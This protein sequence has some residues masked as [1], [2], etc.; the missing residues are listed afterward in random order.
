MKKELYT[1]DNLIFL[2][3]QPRAGS[4]LTQRILGKHHKIHTTSE[5]WLMLRPLYAFR[6]EENNAEYNSTLAR[7]GLESFLS[8]LPHAQ[9]RKNAEQI[10]FQSVAQMYGELYQQAIEASGKDFFLDKTPR[11]YNIIPE[12]KSTFPKANFIFLLRNPLATACSLFTTWIQSNWLSLH[13]L[14]RDIL[15]APYLLVDGIETLK[16]QSIVV[17]YEK[18]LENFDSEIGNVCNKLRIPFDSSLKQYGSGPGCKEWIMGDHRAIHEKGIIDSHHTN[19]WVEKLRDPQLWRIANDYL[20]YLGPELFQKMGYDYDAYHTYLHKIHPSSI[21]LWNT[22]SLEQLTRSL[23]E[24][25][26]IH[27]ELILIRLLNSLQNQGVRKTILFASKSI[28]EK[29]ANTDKK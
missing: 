26:S 21:K 28:K 6:E 22:L 19:R 4:T 24:Y 12:L 3:S 18:I 2:I 7:R 13:F 16:E 11:Y 5:P 25:G 29:I 14:R 10:Y 20:K 17:H 1:G 8:S 15:D 27:Y 23:D 9:E